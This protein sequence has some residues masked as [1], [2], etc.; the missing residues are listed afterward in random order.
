M[1]LCAS[2]SQIT[3]VNGTEKVE[4]FIMT[5]AVNDDQADSLLDVLQSWIYLFW[6]QFAGRAAAKF[7]FVCEHL[8]L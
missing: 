2:T 8:R 4:D 7:G 1:L 3:D 5:T 6:F